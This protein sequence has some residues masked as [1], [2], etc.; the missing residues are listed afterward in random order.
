M[1]L[2]TFDEACLALSALPSLTGPAMLRDTLACDG[3]VL[4]EPVLALRDAPSVAVSAMDGYAVL[5]A[6]LTD[7]VSL[8]HVGVAYPGVPAAVS[9]TPGTCVRI[10]TG[11]PVPPGADRVILQEQ[12]N[13]GSNGLVTLTAKPGSGRH[14]RAAGSDFQRGACLIPAGT[15]LNP[16]HLICASAAD[17]AQ[18]KVRAKPRVGF[19]VTGDELRAPGEVG[20]DAQLPDSLS[21]GLIAFIQRAG[22]EC[23]WFRRAGDSLELLQAHAQA[24]LAICDV[25]V[26]TGGASVGERDFA[27][28][29]FAGAEL[30]YILNK[31]AVKPG[32]PVWVAR[33]DTAYIVGLPGNPGSALVT[34]RL[35]LSPVLRHLSGEKGPAWIWQDVVLSA[36]LPGSGDRT[37]FIY[38]V[39]DGQAL[40]PLGLQ[41]SGAQSPLALATH[42]IRCDPGT[43]PLETGTTVSALP[44]F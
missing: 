8:R 26:V 42:L 24:A 20:S 4:S 11:A 30:D 10:F 15:R 25:I 13:E 33:C 9:V 16:G 19:I 5:D 31:V 34:A 40:K 17:H 1:A 36:P 22:A 18:L 28:S 39:Q 35:F 37:T 3:Y 32:K 44:I 6:D 14:I 2:Q 21:A 29:M 23:V 12:T 38:A 43:G 7:G 27:R 41:D